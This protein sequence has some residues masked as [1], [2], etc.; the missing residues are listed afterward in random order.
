MNHH[1]FESRI[2][3]AAH[4]IEQSAAVGVRKGAGL[5]AT[6]ITTQVAAATHGT[7]GLR[8]TRS[9]KGT[10]ARLYPKITPYG[11]GYLIA[12]TPKGLW[13]ILDSGARKHLVGSGKQRK[14]GNYGKRRKLLKVGQDVVT[15]PFM[16]GGSPGKHTFKHGVELARPK[17]VETI[18]RETSRS[19][20]EAMKP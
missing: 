3:K 2:G 18:H 16:A 11:T 17:V 12:G 20:F 13:S 10:V 19:I 14:N 4:G 6:T 8:G 7:M 5:I 9:K 1:D 15:G